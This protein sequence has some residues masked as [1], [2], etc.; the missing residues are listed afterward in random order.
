LG[1]LGWIAY[2]LSYRNLHTT[3][4]SGWK[5]VGISV[6]LATGNLTGIIFL[7]IYQDLFLPEGSIILLV[8]PT[9]FLVS[10]LVFTV[11]ITKS[12]A[13][14]RHLH[15]LQKSL[16]MSII[17]SFFVLAGVFPVVVLFELRWPGIEPTSLLFWIMMTACGISGV[18]VVYPY[19]YWLAHRHLD[20]WPIRRVGTQDIKTIDFERRFPTFRDAWGVLLLSLTLFIGIF[21]F[22]IISLA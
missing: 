10:W 4:A 17:A 12:T 20:F 5:A 22:I 6:F 16:L 1:P 9:A 14:T 8:I 13:N 7:A 3:K 11:P 15:A 18:V 19:T 2:A 21:G